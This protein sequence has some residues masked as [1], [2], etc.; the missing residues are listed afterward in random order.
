MAAA[1]FFVTLDANY[2]TAVHTRLPHTNLLAKRK[3]KNLGNFEHSLF[4]YISMIL[5]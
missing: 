3:N 1:R 2:N 5:S 4:D